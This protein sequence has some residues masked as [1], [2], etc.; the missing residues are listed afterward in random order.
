M[1]LEPTDDGP[2]RIPP[3]KKREKLIQEVEELSGETVLRCYQC[4]KCTAG[5]PFVEDMDL[6]PNQIIRLVQMGLLNVLDANSIWF[7]AACQIC[8]ARC[9]KGVNLAKIMEALRTILLRRNIDR[10]EPTQLD[11]EEMELDDMPNI[12]LV[13]V[14]RK[15]TG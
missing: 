5:C 4:G 14:F 12:A 9:P 3:K 2:I 15:Q 6:K 11:R 1:T 7:C 8:G 10:L 13:C